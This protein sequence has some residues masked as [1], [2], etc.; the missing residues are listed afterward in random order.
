MAIDL[1]SIGKTKHASPPRMVVHGAEKVGKSTFC[2]QAPSPIFIQTEDGLAG[3]DADAFPLAQSY[4]DVLDALTALCGEHSY[5]TLII[6]SADW[7]EKLIFSEVC[8]REGVTS[9]EKAAGGYGKGYLEA[10]NLWREIL[11]A[12]NY[13]NKEKGMTIIFICHSKVMTFNDPT[14]EPYDVWKL[15]LHSP[16]S[17]NGSCELL[18]EWADV[19]AFAEKEKVIRNVGEKNSDKKINRAT[20]L[21]NRWLH[22]E[23]S[24][25]FMAGNRY[26]L[27]AKVA[28]SWDAFE[29]A[30]QAK[31]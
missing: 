13:L 17:G 18:M 16:K 29:Q 2:A 15:K 31:A 28:L 25:A 20:D 21:K 4:Q 23:G 19:I 27:P 10:L 22:L 7:L 8:Q 26:S 3:I 9:I 5:K 6:D 12:L 11:S 24:P 14:V 30:F 1:N